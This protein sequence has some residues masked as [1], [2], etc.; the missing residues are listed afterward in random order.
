MMTSSTAVLLAILGWPLVAVGQMQPPPSTRFQVVSGANF[1]GA[2]IPAS[3]NLDWHRDNG[4]T[5]FW[6][7]TPE[8][9]EQ[10]ETLLLAYLKAAAEDPLTVSPPLNTVGTCS[11]P[12][13]VGELRAL[14][15][16]LSQYK[17]QYVGRAYG[18]GRR[19]LW[20]GAGRVPG[21][22]GRPRVP[23]APSDSFWKQQLAGH[24]RHHNRARCE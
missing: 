12:S 8:D 5:S 1:E 9:V 10:A 4:V 11:P 24:P 7:P 17:R 22:F 23:G 14:L 16:S 21:V 6:T 15:A 13:S 2:I 20:S 19:I 3:H 18:S